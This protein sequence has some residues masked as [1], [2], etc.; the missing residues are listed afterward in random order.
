ML[1]GFSNFFQW[2][3]LSPKQLTTLNPS[4]FS[5]SKV[6]LTTL[7]KELK[8]LQNLENYHIRSYCLIILDFMEQYHN[9]QKQPSRHV[10]RKSCFENMQQIYRRIPMP[11]CNFNRVAKQL[12]WNHTSAWVFSCKFVAYFQNSFS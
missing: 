8:L 4:N 10:L 11:K 2:V 5:L 1:K 12:Y 9:Q 7:L 6:I 3:I